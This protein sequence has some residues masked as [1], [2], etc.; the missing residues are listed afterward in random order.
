MSDQF[1]NE[2]NWWVSPE[3]YTALVKAV[4]GGS[5]TP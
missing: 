5:P 3:E 2:G 4:R 1:H